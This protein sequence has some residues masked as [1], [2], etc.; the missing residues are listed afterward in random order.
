MLGMHEVTVLLLVT[1]M[2]V[3]RAV[4]MTAV[5]M[6]MAHHQH[7][8]H[9]MPTVCNLETFIGLTSSSRVSVCAACVYV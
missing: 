6:V 8:H 5:V 2:T 3:D 1:I 9:T 4:G 7:H